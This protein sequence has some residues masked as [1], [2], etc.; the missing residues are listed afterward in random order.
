MLKGEIAALT[1]AFLWALSTVLFGQLG[2]S[3]SPLIL[4][5]VKGVLAISLI[6]ATLII[7]ATS[8]SGLS[9]AA[10]LGLLL[11]GAIGIGL[12]DTAYFMTINA[13]GARQALLMESLAPPV[14]ALIAAVLLRETLSWTGWSGILLT[15]L[16]VA[17]VIAEQVPGTTQAQQQHWQGIA[18]GGVAV[19]SQAV[20]AVLSRWALEG[21]VISPLFSSL[22]RIGAGVWILLLGMGS[23]RQRWSQL[24]PLRSP[25][26]LAGV[27]LAAFLGTYLGI[28]LQQTAF[29][30]SPAGIAQALLATSP[31][32]ILPLAALTGDRLTL[33]SLLGVLIAI[34]G[35]WLL[36][37]YA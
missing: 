19:L 7:Q 34:G 29:K 25:R 4:N 31:L 37:R 27:G 15:V 2:K 10:T 36:V 17:W 18:L 23:S 21:T 30:Y 35:I 5:L 14:T 22:L 26:L 6:A 16:G 28:W 32:F 8:I 11:S 20:G 9:L 13:L 33:R 24:M 3:I 1:A 12:G